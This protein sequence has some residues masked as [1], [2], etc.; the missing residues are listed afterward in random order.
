M[1]KMATKISKTHTSGEKRKGNGDGGESASGGS[2]P[3]KVKREQKFLASYSKNNP[4]IVAS[5]IDSTYARCTACEIDFKISH[6]GIADVSKH[7]KSVQHIAKAAAL[8]NSTPL[9]HFL[10]TCDKSVDNRVIRAEVMFTAFLGEHNVP[11]AA[12][13]HAGNLFRSMFPNNDIAEAYSCARTKTAA[14]VKELGADSKAELAQCM[15]RGPFVL[16]TDGS[17]EGEEKYFPIVVSALDPEGNIKTEL[18][19][20]PTCETSA[21]G[22]NI[23]GLLDSE[24]KVFDLSWKNCLAF[25]TDNANVM[26]GSK[27]GVISYIRSKHPETFLA[28]CVCHLLSL[29]VKKAIK[30]SSEFDL[31]DIM[32]QLSWYLSKSTGRQQRL[33]EIQKEW[34]L[35]DH[36]IVDH[37]PT[38]WLS[39]GAALDRALELWKALEKFFKEECTVKASE[40]SSSKS[41]CDPPMRQKLR[42]FFRRRTT[43]LYVLFYAQ[44]LEMFN[45]VNKLEQTDSARIHL[46][47]RDLEQLHRRLL[48]SFIKPAAMNNGTLMKVDFNVAYNIKRDEEIFIGS[49][50]RQHVGS[51]DNKEQKI[52]MENVK[53]FY[54]E[55][56]KYMQR[57]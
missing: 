32:R 40:A 51:V 15:Q 17:Q 24:L 39:L 37:V 19:S 38:R 27:K 41:G 9:G 3:Q 1:K 54:K 50:T 18:L 47:K 53:T 16:G 22:E 5:K 6:G 12:S 55:A 30:E 23:F 2:A 4:C 7:V 43:K 28:R 25:V 29:T 49:A 20:V 46:I 21:T 11:L 34:G 36:K 8:K 13:D 35:P 52:F 14:I 10:E 31:D 57:R 45:K 33:K 42:D 48:V 44:V 56:C 26:V